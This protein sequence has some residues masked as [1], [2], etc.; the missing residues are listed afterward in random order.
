MYVYIYTYIHI[1]IYI[2]IYVYAYLG[3]K[4][5]QASMHLGPVG[6]EG[7]LGPSRS[8]DPTKIKSP[9]N[10]SKIL[11]KP[12]RKPPKI[13]SWNS[14]GPSWPP[15]GPSWRQ[16]APKNE[17]RPKNWSSDPSPGLHFG[18]VFQPCWHY[19]GPSCAPR[20]HGNIIL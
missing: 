17:K 19:I 12:P 8:E 14:F 1:P 7:L 20:V 11:P 10:Y 18:R 15:L 4:C 13:H 16:E 6:N 3:R 2:Y 5:R 9:Q